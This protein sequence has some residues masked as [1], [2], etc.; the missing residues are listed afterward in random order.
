V[1]DF[2]KDLTQSAEITLPAWRRRPLLEKVVGTVAW[3][4]ERQQ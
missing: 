3:I 1:T 4:L 2:E